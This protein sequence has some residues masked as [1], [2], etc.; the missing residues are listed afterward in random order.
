MLR[1]PVCSLPWLCV[2][3]SL[4]EMSKVLMQIRQRQCPGVKE[5]V[6]IDSG[7]AVIAEGFW[8]ASKGREALE[9]VWDEGPLAKLSTK[10]MREEFERLAKTP[11]AVAKKKGDPQRSFQRQPSNSM[12]SMKFPFLPMLVWSL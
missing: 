11:G 6:Q 12:R 5:V 4:V 2:L 1:S 3:L 10:G 9:I 7:V 8:S